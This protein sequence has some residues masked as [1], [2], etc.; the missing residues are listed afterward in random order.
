MAGKTKAAAGML[1]ARSGGKGKRRHAFPPLSPRLRKL[2]KK[3]HA[4]LERNAPFFDKHFKK[5]LKTHRGHF[6]VMK[7][8]EI[9]GIFPTVGEAATVGENC[10]DGVFSLHEIDDTP[11][12]IMGAVELVD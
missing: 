1:T 3:Q 12:F 6:A 11:I 9:I 10:P 4:E 5:L 8:G 7:D 2:R